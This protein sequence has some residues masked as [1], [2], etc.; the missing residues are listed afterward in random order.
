MSSDSMTF[1]RRL[2][3]CRP[4]VNE[5]EKKLRLDFIRGLLSAVIYGGKLDTSVD[6]QI[7]QALIDRWFQTSY[8]LENFD[9]RNEISV[10]GLSKN[11]NK[12][13]QT[14]LEG[15]LTKGLDILEKAT[16][17]QKRWQTVR[18]IEISL[19]TIGSK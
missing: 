16:N 10:L 3:S 9:P 15:R 7:L 11:A 18:Q 14:A 8:D 4:F 2:M 5:K 12:L 6:H 19:A 17:R 13:R 1:G